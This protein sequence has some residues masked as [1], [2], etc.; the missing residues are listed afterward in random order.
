MSNNAPEQ[1]PLTDRLRDELL[2]A[3]RAVI[4]DGFLCE[5]LIDKLC[6]NER[7]APSE[8]EYLK[9]TLLLRTLQAAGKNIAFYRDF[10]IRCEIDEIQSLLINEYPIIGKEDLL[11]KPRLFYPNYGDLY[12]WN[13][14]GRTSGTTG[15]PLH[16]VRSVWST[17]WANAFKKRH[18]RWSGFKEGMP[19][20]TLRG[21]L[22]V[23]VKKETP[24]FWFFSR[25]NNQLIL[26]SRH[27]KPKFIE[28]IVEQ[29]AAFGPYLLEAYPSTAYE[30]ASHLVRTNR[31]LKIAY[32]FTGSEVLYPHQRETIEK[33][34]DAQVMD[35]YGMAERVAYA[36]EC[37]YGNLH[38]NSE[39]SFVEIVDEFGRPTDDYGSIV[40]TTFHNLSMPLIRYRLSDRAKWK[41]GSCR[42]ERVYP[43]IEPVTGKNEDVI[44]GSDGNVVSPSVITFA[45]KGL[46]SIRQSQ[47]A[48][49]GHG[50]WQVRVVPMED[51]S[52]TERRKLIQN[53]KQLVDPNLVI[54][55]VVLNEIP[56]TKAGKYK[57]VVNESQT[58]S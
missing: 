15:T 5:R 24:P 1:P 8:L 16:I 33:G 49:V 32:I 55:V 10:K 39:Y 54:E 13:I 19:R 36:T 25:C 9:N 27:L 47:V 18:W 3:S 11:A 35:H 23:P 56:R 43:M 20:A 14:V 42:C 6:K 2:Y 21:D 30:L 31:Q 57:W 37:E 29:L 22:V 26:S 28:R 46:H 44:H 52:E 7:A 50:R 40:G 17:I 51:F 38:V 34:F 12:P 41:H 53:I 58:N 48:Q 4:R 45:F